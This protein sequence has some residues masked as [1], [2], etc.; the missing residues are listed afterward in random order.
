M[1]LNTFLL[2]SI[3]ERMKSHQNLILYYSAK[4]KLNNNKNSQSNYKTKAIPNPLVSPPRNLSHNAQSL[5]FRPLPSFPLKRLPRPE[6]DSLTHLHDDRDNLSGGGP[7]DELGQLS[8][9]EAHFPD[10]FRT[11]LRINQ[12]TPPA[13]S[14]SA[15]GER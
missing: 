6:T 10:C 9:R 4:R 13:C 7:I 15:A 5:P 2:L 11:T 1:N 14:V 12:D 8:L 3:S